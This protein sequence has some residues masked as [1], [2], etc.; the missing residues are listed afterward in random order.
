[1]KR[2]IFLFLITIVLHNNT[3]QGQPT[4]SSLTSKKHIAVFVYCDETVSTPI[5][6][7]RAKLTSSLINSEN[8]PY[9]V[10][11]R[12][13]EILKVLKEEYKYQGS[14]LVKDDQLVSLGEQLGA[15]YICVVNVTYYSE[16]NQFFFECKTIDIEKRLIEKQAYYPKDANT[17]INDLTPQ[18]QIR[19][20]GE[21]AN[22]L[23]P[24]DK[25]EKKNIQY[26]T[27]KAYTG[28][29]IPAN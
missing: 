15:N 2:L 8:S 12:T 18:T 28:R 21:L 11:D 6:A 5:N 27:G 20:A 13:D 4:N 24:E 22:Q 19:V 26:S 29:I 25:K 1:M 23:Q 10:V 14:G 9:D 16:Y 7:L 17:T 3:I